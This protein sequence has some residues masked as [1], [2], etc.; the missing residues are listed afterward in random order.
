IFSDEGLVDDED[1]RRSVGVRVGEAAAG[2]EGNPHGGKVAWANVGKPAAALDCADTHSVAPGTAVERNVGGCG[3][4]LN[5]WDAAHVFD[6]LAFELCFILWLDIQC[7]E[8][9][10]TKHDAAFAHT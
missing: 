4:V 10:V 8:I 1:Q 2:E 7:G 9:E 5:A 3:R 6:Q